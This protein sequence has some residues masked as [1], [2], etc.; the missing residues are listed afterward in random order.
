M[1]DCVKEP[2]IAWNVQIPNQREPISLESCIQRTYDDHKEVIH[3][4]RDG[5]KEAKDYTI[6][7]KIN[8]TP[9]L[10]ILSLCRWDVH[11]RKIN[12]PIQIPHTLSI[13]NHPSYTLRGIICHSGSSIPSGHYV[14]VVSD[15]VHSK[16]LL[17]DDD[18]QRNIPDPIPEVLLRQAYGIIYEKD[19]SK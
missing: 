15:S 17:I 5:D 16:L 3:Y 18:N 4:K 11:S 10:W 8:T 1:V 14:S 9:D 13:P 6:V 19:E 7:R 12:T 2:Q